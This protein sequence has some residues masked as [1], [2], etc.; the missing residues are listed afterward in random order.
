MKRVTT[1]MDRHEEEKKSSRK[2][3]ALPTVEHVD[4]PRAA[5]SFSAFPRYGRG[6]LSN[7]ISRWIA[8]RLIYE[9]FVKN[10]SERDRVNG[11]VNEENESS[12]SD[13]DNSL[14]AGLKTAAGKRYQNN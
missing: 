3:T 2:L 4:S 1:M 9:T 11:K 5:V 10:E 7:S 14:Y 13:S 6:E 8:Q 12:P